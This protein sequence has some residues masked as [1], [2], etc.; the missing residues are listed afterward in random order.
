L[1]LLAG[2]ADVG[3][4]NRSPS[5]FHM[6]QTFTGTNGNQTVI[7]DSHSNYNLSLKNV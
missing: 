2:G 4:I 3:G 5:D 1:S 6:S 7:P